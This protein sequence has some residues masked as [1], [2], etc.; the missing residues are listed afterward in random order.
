MTSNT[1]K[2]NKDNESKKIISIANLIKKQTGKRKFRKTLKKS[3][4]NFENILT[5]YI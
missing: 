2:K 5:V 4:F 3:S 1:Q